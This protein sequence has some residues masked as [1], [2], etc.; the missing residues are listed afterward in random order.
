MVILG[1]I[2][3]LAMP[4]AV[5]GNNFQQV[6]NDRCLYKLQALTRQMLSEND[7]SPEDCLTAFKQFDNDGD[8]LIDEKEFNHFVTGVLGLQLKKPDLVKLWGMLDLN[9]SGSVNFTEFTEM[10]FPNHAF[11]ESVEQ[12]EFSFKAPSKTEDGQPLMKAAEADRNVIATEIEKKLAHQI[13]EEV[14]SCDS[15]AAA[16]PTSLSLTAEMSE[17]LRQ[18][19]AAEIGRCMVEHTSQLAASVSKLEASVVDMR[20]HTLARRSRKHLR[21]PGEGEGSN[22]RLGQNA[23]TEQSSSSKQLVR[24]SRRSPPTTEHPGRETSS[25]ISR[26]HQADHAVPAL[27][28]T[29]SPAPGLE[30]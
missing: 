27:S 24:R 12:T 25:K 20:A 3:F 15:A 17:Q 11:S 28:E 6:W 29:R 26:Q 13:A 5:V 7:M 21:T 9:R 2:L 18:I 23:N 30:A 10:L 8:G 14:P 19:V 4:L 16:A 1:G 22:Y